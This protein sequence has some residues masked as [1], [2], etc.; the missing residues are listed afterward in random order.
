MSISDKEWETIGSWVGTIVKPL[1]RRIEQL[2]ERQFRFLGAWSEG[3]EAHPGNAVAHDGST[4]I[5]SE[6]TTKK[7]G[8]AHSGWILACKKGRDARGAKQ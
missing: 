6:T 3:L 5:C 8:T 4:W 1:Q 2:E 7:P